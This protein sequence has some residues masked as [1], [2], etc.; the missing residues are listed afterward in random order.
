VHRL[1]FTFVVAVALPAQAART[2]AAEADEVAEREITRTLKDALTASAE[3]AIRRLGTEDGFLRNQQARIALPEGL[4]RAATG[5][6]R[7]GMGRYPAELE[8]TLNRAAESAVPELRVPFIDAI[9]RITFADVRS[10]V[11]AGD[12][13][14]AQYFRRQT[15]ADIFKRFLPA[16]QSATR[17]LHTAEAYQQV[18]GRAA[19]V[20]LLSADAARLDEHIA[21]KALDAVYAA[22]ADEE[23][24]MR[25]YS[26]RQTRTAVRRVAGTR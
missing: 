8:T 4:S 17:R 19:K 2:G 14:A 3:A 21:A 15:N 12:E 1:L 18:A 5:L 7:F 9:S 20:G 24:A 10:A 16:V 26:I 22:M 11:N 13:T 25:A 6:R 23:R